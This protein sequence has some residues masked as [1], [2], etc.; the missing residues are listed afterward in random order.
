MKVRYYKEKTKIY[1]SYLIKNKE[2]PYR[3]DNI[4][5]IRKFVKN[6]PTT[7]TR[8]SYIAET[9]AHNRLYKLGLFKKHTKNCDL[10]EDIKLW[11]EIVYFIIGI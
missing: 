1:D 8:K 11:K 10:E 7:R 6:L 2:I 9:K 4:L 3:I 5:H